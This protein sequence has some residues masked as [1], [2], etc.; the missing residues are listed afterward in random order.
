MVSSVRS[1][2]R[3]VYLI[4]PNKIYLNF[5]KDLEKV[6]SSNKV[7]FF[8]LRLKETPKNSILK[9]AKK[10]KKITKKNIKIYLSL[11]DEK[12]YALAMV[13]ISY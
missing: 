9:I 1:L 8:Q 10:I 12:K 3:L 6:L 13:V 2:K 4:S 11:S 7:S 5:Y